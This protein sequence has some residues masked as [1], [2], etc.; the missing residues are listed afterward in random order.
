MTSHDLESRITVLED[1]EAIKKSHYK[2][3][4]EMD[5]GNW[6]E[7]VKLFT[8]DAKID[9][10]DVGKGQGTDD[11]IKFY[12][13]TLPGTF[14]FLMHCNHN[15]LVNVQG[16]KATGEFYL[17]M[18][19]THRKENEPLWIAGKY[20]NEYVKES[21]E[22]KVKSMAVKDIYATPYGGEGWV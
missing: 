22:W 9:F 5:K 16:D 21:G 12:K 4:Y 1:I 2:Y 17:A 13:E 15:P 7:V 20:E 6:Q 10:G 14:S 3:C 19:A 11:I 18:S 8:K